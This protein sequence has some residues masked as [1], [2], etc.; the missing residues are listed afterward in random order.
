MLKQ[1]LEYFLT[2]MKGDKE[3]IIASIQNYKQY[4]KQQLVDRFN[5]AQ[6]LGIIGARAQA[7]DLFALGVVFKQVFGHSPV[8]VTDGVILGLNGRIALVGDK[9]FY[10]DEDTNILITND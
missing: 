8:Y 1:K 10:V 2:P 3:K 4:T 9:F 6:K 5:E 7:L